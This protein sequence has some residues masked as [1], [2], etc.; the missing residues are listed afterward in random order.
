MAFGMKA[1]I[2]RD[3]ME[4]VKYDA[5]AGRMFRVDYDPNTHEKSPVD[6]TSPPP[7]FAIDFGSL[8]VG[9]GHFAPGG[10]ELRVVPIGC[11]LP[12]YPT[13][14]DDKGRLMFKPVFRVTVFGNILNG[15]REFASSANCVLE[16]VDDLYQKFCAAP[17][18]QTGRI[19]IVE[20]TKTILT[21]MGKGARQTNIYV[22]C[23]AIAG[24]TERVSEMGPRTVPPPKPQAASSVV[25]MPVGQGAPPAG[26]GSIDNDAIPFTAS[27]Q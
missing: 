12:P 6:I 7:K 26:G 16:A 4:I 21:Q 23:F 1:P 19:P 17:E 13:E 15:L 24:W 22:P 10:P 8:Q 3:F 25:Q 27:W 5:R 9:Y 2:V 11:E 20:L 18:A 14:K